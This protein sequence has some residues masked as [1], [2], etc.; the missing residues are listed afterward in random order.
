MPDVPNFI[1]GPTGPGNYQQPDYRIPATNPAVG[2]P[3]TKFGNPL[4]LTW[5]L[6]ALF[7]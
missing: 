6:P 3:V 2:A 4:Q 7:L 1:P 5:P